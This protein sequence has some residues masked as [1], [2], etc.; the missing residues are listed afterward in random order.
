MNNSLPRYFRRSLLAVALTAAVCP[1][2]HAAEQPSQNVQQ[3]DTSFYLGER[4][5]VAGK[6][7]ID[8]S[9]ALTSVDRMAGDLAQSANIDYAWQLVGQLPGVTLTE[10]NQGTSSG[11][12]SFRGFNGEGEVNAVKLLIDGIPAN[13]NDGNMP[14]IDAVL[15]LEIATLEVVRGTTDPRYGLHNI[16]GNV[17]FITRSGGNYLDSRVSAGSFDKYDVQAAAGVEHGDFSQNYAV[18]YRTGKLSLIHI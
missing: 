6:N 15:P 16:A 10:F 12:L 3:G 9:K 11:K 18:G 2:V 4:I 1:A 17:A 7:L 5:E 14:Y 13:S 8:A